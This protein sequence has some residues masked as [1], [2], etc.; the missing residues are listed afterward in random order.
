[1]KMHSALVLLAVAMLAGCAATSTVGHP[2]TAHPAAASTTPSPAPSASA[3][4]YTLSDAE[5]AQCSQP[6][7]I[8]RIRAAD[9]SNSVT[10]DNSYPPLPDDPN[11]VRE[12]PAA[13]A[14]Q[15]QVWA[16]LSPADRLYKLC[17]QAYE[18]GLT[19][20]PAG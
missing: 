13:V 6:P 16:A 5:L 7:L 19:P 1:V 17:F 9:L 10:A 4:L 11:I 15:I 8:D 12:G 14:A 3:S 18:A 2:D 20:P